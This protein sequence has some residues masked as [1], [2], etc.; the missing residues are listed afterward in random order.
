MFEDSTFESNGKIH[1]RSSRWALATLLL[2]CS[3]LA[4]IV[5]LPLI[6]TQALPHQALSTLLVTPPSP[7][8]MTEAPKPAEMRARVPDSEMMRDQLLAPSKIPDKVKYVD[9]PES[10]PICADCIAAG[11]GIPGATGP[12]VPGIFHIAPPVVV[13]HT[14]RI[15]SSVIEGMLVA[16]AMPAYPAIARQ[17][18]TQGTVV[19]AAIISKTGTIES[20]HV[21]SGPSMLQRAA[22]DA[23]QQWRYRPYLLDGSAV[24][25][26]TNVSV[27]FKLE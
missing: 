4:L 1:T 22:I 8:Q 14:V 12:G 20:L 9:K 17:T 13:P 16:K 25:V 27:V 7:M 2:N 19:L 24:E 6:Y 21:V 18:R 23:V 15:S 5:L 3:I 10:T 11:P 26:E